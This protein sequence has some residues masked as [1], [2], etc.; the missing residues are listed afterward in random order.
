MCR[1]NCYTDLWLT[2][3]L[4]VAVLVSDA[5]AV[6]GG[7]AKMPCDI[8]PPIPGDKVYL[9][10]WYKEGAASPIY[11]YIT[12]FV[13]IMVPCIVIIFQYISNKMQRYTVYFIWK[14]LYM[15]RVVPPSNIRSANNCIYNIWYLSHRYCYL[16]LSWKSWNWFEG[17]VGGVLYTQQWFTS[18]RF[19]DSLQTGSGWDILIL[20]ASCPDTIV[21]Y[22]VKY[23]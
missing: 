16:P 13:K 1:T 3:L 19:A 2:F 17:A 15:F 14:L 7:V 23:S 10:I 12:F 4:S 5:Q 9:V 6:A 8:A 11:R 22:T 21:V 20:L 18:Y